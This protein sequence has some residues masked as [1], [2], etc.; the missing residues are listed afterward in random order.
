MTLNA[1][2]TGSRS[3]PVAAKDGG[4]FQ[5][6]GL[7][8]P[9]SGGGSGDISWT[10]TVAHGETLTITDAQ[11]RFGTRTNVKPL[12]VNTG[13]GKTDTAL[14]RDAGDKFPAASV[15]QT[16]IKNG[17]VPGAVGLD[18][19]NNSTDAV[20]DDVSL[21][22]SKPFVSYVERFYAFDITDPAYQNG[23]GGFNLKAFRIWA[24]GDNNNIYHSYQE[25]GDSGL[26]FVEN[27]W[28]GGADYFGIT[29]VDF[30][31]FSDEV[32]FENSDV[33]VENG[34]FELYRNGSGPLNDILT[35]MT[36]KTGKTVPLTEMN[37]D[38]V[39]NNTGQSSI[40]YVG[41]ICLDDEYRGVYLGNA[42]TLAACTKLVRQ[43]QVAWGAGQVQIKAVESFVPI[44][45]AYLYIRTGK[46]TWVS[47]DGVQLL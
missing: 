15:Y 22:P 24:S 25:S 34:V 30:S 19:Y 5:S 21:D 38:Q 42:S 3:L 7:V 29:H 39:S 35:P 44:S 14:G 33:D 2:F 20:F 18:H 6:A 41:Y 16:T 47:T 11:S 17:S 9:P 1:T 4:G 10:G 45:G 32:L 8:V 23:A 12:Y 36:R 40:T 37:L 46:D 27:I 26:Y 43:P 28:P 13:G 31:W